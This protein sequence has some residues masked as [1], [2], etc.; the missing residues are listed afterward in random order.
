MSPYILNTIAGLVL[1]PLFTQYLKPEEYA[2]LALIT[3]ITTFA[4][5]FTSLKLESAVYRFHSDFKFKEDKSDFLGTIFITKL[6]AA[7]IIS[8]IVFSF[9]GFFHLR[10][11]NILNL[12]FSP[13]IIATS[14]IIFFTTLSTQQMALWVA[15]E[16]PKAVTIISLCN[17]LIMNVLSVIFIVLLNEEAW[18]KIKAVL[19]VEC[20]TFFIVLLI[21]IHKINFTFSIE[22]LKK[23]LEFSLPLF[24]SSL[25][26]NILKNSDRFIIAQYA[27]YKIAGVS[28][29]QVG[30]LH[31]ADKFAQLINMP[32]KGVEKSVTPYIF[33]KPDRVRQEKALISTYKLWI[34]LSGFFLL[35]FLLIIEIFFNIFIDKEYLSESMFLAA[36]LLAISYF[37]IG[38]YTFF[39]IAIGISKKTSSIFKITLVAT[40]MNLILNILL[41]PIY[42]WII[43]PTSTLLSTIITHGL[44][45]ISS[46]KNAKISFPK[47]FTY[48]CLVIVL[49]IYFI[50]GNINI[51]SGDVIM[52]I[53]IVIL[54][55]LIYLLVVYFI[56]DLK[57]IIN[58]L[59]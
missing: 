53:L 59:K 58:K 39:S 23:S 36:K 26:N 57:S 16:N 15:E 45:S 21:T 48:K 25:T 51:N 55:S 3:S 33:N 29:G 6:I 18:G 30:L 35:G 28:L 37:L 47:L 17:F 49:V 44:M 52:P 12:Q 50:S 56:F 31:I 41:I 40:I 34:I 1:V 43:A 13:F 19:I 5:T 20:L 11:V 27:A 46:E 8:S 38:S 9:F 42:G 4:L 32:W 22:H 24:F 10:G 7:L 14:F 2:I 54:H